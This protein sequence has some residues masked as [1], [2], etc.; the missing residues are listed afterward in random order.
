MSQ[1]SISKSRIKV[2]TAAITS[3]DSI[4]SYLV[5]AA[6]TLLTSTLVSGKQSLDVNVTQM[7]A[8]SI[9]WTF[10]YAEDAAHSSGDVGAFMLAV[11]RDANTSFVGTDG[12]YAPFALN[13]VG[14]LKTVDVDGNALLTTID[15]DTSTLAAV[16]F[17][18]QTTLALAYGELQTIDTSAALLATTVVDGSA[19]TWDGANTTFL[20][21]LVTAGLTQVALPASALANRRSVTVQNNGNKSVFIGPT[22]VTI[23]G[24][25]KGIEI[26]AGATYHANIGA[27]IALFVIS[28]TA[29]QEVV[30]AEMR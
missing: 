26:A 12:D 24:A 9:D 3:G 23:S 4:A 2:D 28:G 25:T 10:D 5:D 27:S 22:G 20:T 29:S 14:Y 7:P 6:G 11:R 19:K 13:A 8:L 16:D 15:A 21:T 1:S 18:T 30:I 17:A